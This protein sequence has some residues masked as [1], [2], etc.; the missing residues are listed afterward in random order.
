[1]EICDYVN[2]FPNALLAI[3]ADTVF[4]LLLFPDGPRRTIGH[5]IGL[6]RPEAEAEAIEL[7][8]G[9]RSE[10]MAAAMKEDNDIN[11]LQQSGVTSRLARPGRLSQLETTV[12]GL[13]ELHSR[14]HRGVGRRTRDV[15]ARGL[16]EPIV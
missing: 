3:R 12:W 6:A 2:I 8:F 16:F 9:M 10:F 11:E 1:M 5:S 7:S 14:S 13:G 4:V 15:M